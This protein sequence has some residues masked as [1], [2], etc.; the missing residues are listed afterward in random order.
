MGLKVS[1]LGFGVGGLVIKVQ[2]VSL[3]VWGLGFGV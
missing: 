2:G 3:R 1:V